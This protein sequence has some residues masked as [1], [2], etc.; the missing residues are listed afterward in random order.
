MQKRKRV[1]KKIISPVTKIQNC[2]FT[3]VHWDSQA[4]VSVELVAQALLNLTTLFKTQ[5]ISGNLLSI[6]P[7]IKIK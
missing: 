6:N 4:L 1:Q 2:N 7:D 3:G 5:G